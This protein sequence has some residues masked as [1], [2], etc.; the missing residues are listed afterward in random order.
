MLQYFIHLFA[1]LTA[2][3]KSEEALTRL[4]EDLERDITG[5]RLSVPVYTIVLGSLVVY[6]VLS[7]VEKL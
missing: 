5:M 2:K 6:I 3:D 4:D 7:L 1:R